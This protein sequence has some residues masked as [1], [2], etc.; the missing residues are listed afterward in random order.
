MKITTKFHGIREYKEKDILTFKKGLPGFEHL[1]QFILFSLEHND[2]FNILQSIEDET[3]G[4]VVTS[5]FV[6]IK[7]YEFKL[8]DN[9]IERLDIKESAD[10]LVM[11]T[12]TLSSRVENITVNLKAPIIINIKEKLGEQIILDK[13]QY[14]IKHP[15]VRE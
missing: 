9:V 5:P 14:K 8:E 7:D 4:L 11:N 13:E 6:I 3:I 2:I 15:L 10:V 1:K 12:V